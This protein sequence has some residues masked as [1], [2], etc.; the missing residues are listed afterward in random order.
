MKPMDVTIWTGETI[1]K[2]RVKAGMTQKEMADYLGMAQ[3]NLCRTEA[4]KTKCGRMTCIAWDAIQSK[5][6]KEGKVKS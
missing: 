3:P 6:Y 4:G 2:L 1:M 5:L